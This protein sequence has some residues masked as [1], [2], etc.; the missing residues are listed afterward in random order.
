[1]EATVQAP[2][3]SVGVGNTDEAVVKISPYSQPIRSRKEKGKVPAH[4]IPS[5]PDDAA[6]RLSEPD[7]GVGIVV[8]HAQSDLN[9]KSP[10]PTP[11]PSRGGPTSHSARPSPS[12][13]TTLGEA[14][15]GLEVRSTADFHFCTM[16]HKS[17]ES[18]AD[19]SIVGNISCAADSLFAVWP[20]AARAIGRP[21][22]SARSSSLQIHVL[23]G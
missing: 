3:P 14:C 12:R 11:P 21:G 19:F 4:P 6:K 15:E 9:F 22:A 16:R 8:H 20:R 5:A 7:E 1:M 23:R 18:R 2:S 10:R 13:P 17:C